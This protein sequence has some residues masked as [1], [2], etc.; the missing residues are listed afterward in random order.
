[1]NF[2]HSRWLHILFA[3]ISV[4]ALLIVGCGGGVSSDSPTTPDVKVR[5]LTG[6]VMIP[7]D[8]ASQRASLR[9][10]A[11]LIPAWGAKVWIEGHSEISPEYTDASGTYTF[12]GVPADVKYVVAKSTANGKILKQR[13][14]VSINASDLT[15]AAPNVNLEEALTVLTG[16]LKD[17]SN[18]FLPYGTELTLWGEPFQVGNDGTFTTLPLPVSVTQAEIF[19]KIF[20]SSA[21]SSFNGSFISG[22]TPAFVEQTVTAPDSSN[23]APSGVLIAE[24]VSG[25]K[26]VSCLAGDRM[27]LNLTPFDANADDLPLLEILW[28]KSKGSLQV[29][30]DKKSAT[31][32]AM[33]SYGVATVSVT[34]T[35]PK[36]ASGKVNLRMLV[37]VQT[38]DEADGKP[39]VILSRTPAHGATG[40][41]MDSR[42]IV[43]F[44]EILL[45]S[46]VPSTAITVSSAGTTVPGTAT[47]SADRKTITWA[48]ATNLPGN[49]TLNVTLSAAIADN[50]GNTIGNQ[51]QWSFSTVSRPYVTVTT[52]LTNDTTPLV[53][54]TVDSTPA[55]MQ[56][57]VKGKTYTP[58]INGTAWTVQVSD[59]LAD[60][61][62]DVLASAT[63]SFGINGSDTTK[64][65]LQIDTLAPVAELS[66][67]PAAV[68]NLT[69]T[70]ITVGGAGVASYRYTLDGGTVSAVKSINEKI[71]LTGL[72]NGIHQLA[73]MGLDG[74]GNWQTAADATSYN[75]K[76]DTTVKTA[77]LSD[78][79]P[80]LTNQTSVS[81]TVGGTGVTRYKYSLDGGSWS[82][83]IVA[84][85]T[86]KIS[87]TGLVSG[88]HTLKVIGG[89]DIGN[90]QAT[91]SATSFTWVVDTN[92]KIAV[93]SQTPTNPSN[94]KTAAIVVGG[95][96]VVSYK[97]S[98]NDGSW[99]SET[100]VAD[101]IEL[102]GLT[103]GN[104]V[105][106]VV[107][108]DE[109]GN[110]QPAGSATVFSWLID[111]ADLTVT[112]NRK[113]TQPALSNAATVYFVAQ[114]NKTVT[115]FIGSDVTLTG[116]ANPTTA[117][118]SPAASPADGKTFLVAVSGMTVDGT[119]IVSLAANVASD[120][121]GNP[122]K[123]STST[124]NQVLRDTVAP[125]TTLT[126]LA[127]DPTNSSP[128]SVT[129]AFSKAISGLT[130]D[131]LAVTNGTAGNLVETTASKTWTFTVVPSA[132]GLVTIDF[133]AAKVIDAAGNGNLAATQLSF[134]YDSA[135]PAA[136]F[137]TTASPTTNIN[138]VPITITFDKAVISFALTDLTLNN[139][140]VGNLAEVVTGKSWT[141]DLIP[142]GNGPVSVD[143]P[144]G[145]VSDAVGNLNT[146]AAQLSFVYDNRKP[147]PLFA[148][149]A[150][151]TTKISPIPFTITFDEAV[152]GFAIG[153]LTVAN[154]T[155]GS[156]VEVVAGKVWSFNVTSPADGAVTV[157]LA[158]D[159]AS[160]VAVNGNAAATPLSVT[161]DS[162]KPTVTLTT[163]AGANP[164]RISPITVTVSFSETVTG[165]ELADLG[166]ING[167]AGN[168]QVLTAGK[169]WKV[170]VTPPAP[171]EVTVSLAAGLASDTAGNG[172]SA[173]VPLVV[174]FDQTEPNAVLSTTASDPTNSLSVPLTIT[175]SEAVL[176]FT[177]ADISVGNGTIAN[178]ATTDNKIW[179]AVITPS[180]DGPVT[181]NLPA[182]KA[183]D[184]AGN[185]NT[186]ATALSF[187]YDSLAPGVVFSSAAPDPT[188]A[189]PVPVTITFSEAMTGF[190]AA[191]LSIG[192]GSA[193]NLSTSDN[194]IW[195]VD[196]V[197]SANDNAV[198][199]LDLAAGKATDAAGNGNTVATQFSITYDSEMPAVALTTASATTN[200]NPIPV[201]VTFS[202]SVTGFELGDLQVVNGTP[203]NLATADNKVYT[204][205][206]TPT[207]SNLTVN[208][209]AGKATDAA[210][211]G[212]TAAAPL[213]IAYDSA[214]PSVAFSTT[215]SSTTRISPVPMTVTF[216]EAVSGF[217]AGD[218][219]IANGSV[220]ALT[221]VDNKVWTF[222][223]TGSVNGP[224]TIDLAADRVVDNAGN[225]NTAA[226]Q[227]SLDF[228]NVEPTVTM[229]APALTN[230]N[231]VAVTITFSKAVTGLTLAAL[232]VTNG[233]PANLNTVDNI[234][235]TAEV[236]PT[237]EGLVT[238]DLAAAKAT[239]VAGNPNAAANT[240]N[241]VYDSG[242][243]GATLAST[244]STTTNISPIPVTIAFS[245]VVASFDVNDLT[246][247]NATV[248]NF[249][250]TVASQTWTF[251]LTP[252]TQGAVT[253]EVADS[254]TEDAAGNG[255][256]AVTQISRTYDSAAP[257]TPI[258]P[259]ITPVG[260]TVV[261]NFLNSTNI[262]L[263]AQATITAGQATGGYAELLID[264][265]AF[266]P[267]LKDTVIQAADTIVTFDAGLNSA[268]ALQA[269]FTAGGE[270]SVR[271]FDAADNAIVSVGN[272][273][274]VVDYSG[275]SAPTSV[276]VSAAG[277]RV[278][279]NAVNTTNTN[280]TASAIISAGQATGGSAEL[281][282]NGSSFAGPI[283]DTSILAGDT[284]VDFTAGTS[285]NAALQA[286][287]TSGGVI[288]VRLID[289]A[290]NVITSSVGNPT[291]LVDY[292]PPAAPTS[293]LL[294]PIGGTITANA[295]NST[296]TG[297][298]AQATIAAGQA[299]G[300]SAE[301]LVGGFSFGPVIVDNNI[302]AGDIVVN[303]PAA[304]SDNPGLR[305]AVPAG[306]EI[307][308]KLIDAAGNETVS[309]TGNPVLLVDYWAPAAPTSITLTPVGGTVVANTLNTT[310]T[311][312]DVS[313]TIAAG[314]ATGGTA[315]LLLDGALLAGLK[316]TDI[317]SGDISV[318]FSTGTSD[319]AALRSA[320]SAGGVISIRLKD[321]T[322]NS[323]VSG[324]G[325]NPTLT[326]DYT[327][328]AAPTSVT[329]TPIS[330]TVVANTL[331]TTSTNLTA[332][333]IIS[334]GQAT[335]GT[336]ELLIGG[337]SF[338]PAI[339][340]NLIAA[341]DTSVNFSAGLN[342]TAAVQTAF[343]ASGSISVRITDAAGNISVSTV[344]NPSL[345]V[346]YTPPTA[347][348]EVVLLPT[349]GT[350]YP[351][352]LN[353]TN[354]SLQASAKIT[355]G[356]A[357]GGEAELLVAGNSFA[358]AIKDSI[359]NA[360]DISVTF[361]TAT[362]SNAALQAFVS[363]GNSGTVSV[364]V[365]DAAGNST[366]S[367][368][369]NPALV[370]DYVAPSLPTGIV[371]TPVGGTVVANAINT[372]NTNLT[373][374]ATIAAGEATGGEAELLVG[375]NS[376]ATPL[377]DT[378]ILA[379][380]T[381]V[382][383]S[384]GTANNPV[385]Q[386]VVTSGGVISVR[387]RDSVGNVSISTV[388]PT[389]LVDYV[390]PS[391]PSGVLIGAVGGT[392]VANALNSTNINLLATASIIANENAS[393]AELLIGGVPF[394][395]P[396]K[397][398]QI[399]AADNTVSFNPGYGSTAALQAAITAGGTISVRVKDRAGNVN[400]STV[401]NPVLTVDY[402]APAAPTSVSLTPVGGTVVAN[403]LNSSNT[404]LTAGATITADQA[405]GGSAELLIG[406]AAFATPIRDLSI[407]AGET[408]VAFD[409]GFA[410]SDALQNAITFG[411]EISV[412]ITDAVGN[413]SVSTVANPSLTVDYSYSSAGIGT[414]KFVPAGTFQ[415][416]ATSTNR[417]SL[418]KFRMS[419][420]EITR[421]Q[422]S[423]IMGSD[424]TNTAY[425][426]G[427]TDPVQMTGWY[428]A[429]A[430][431][432]KLSIA[433][434]LT[435]VYAVSGVNFSTL[436]YA[437]IPTT[438]N[439]NWNAATCNW[440]ANGYRLP[441]EMEW[442]WAAMD[443]DRD[444][445]GQVNTTGYQ[446]LFSG[447]DGS[448]TAADF[449][450]FS[451]AAT[452]PVGYKSANKL[453]I[454][455]L[456]GNVWEWC[457]DYYGVYP[458]GVQ[459]DYRGPVGGTFRITRGGSWSDNASFLTVA[460]RSYDYPYYQAET[461]GFRVVRP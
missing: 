233:T 170:D 141:F 25:V 4:V 376:F 148:T 133:A 407:L 69:Q 310:N 286:A 397:D 260:G 394:A 59:T 164:T 444:N 274:L 217:E 212:N 130:L 352:T 312:L 341:G 272:P 38:M 198:V 27:Y 162:V 309:T 276:T 433:E 246:V 12:K 410:S 114:F 189:S 383:F 238:V 39:P 347:P 450:W 204:F 366:V 255:N 178:L 2:L 249:V 111:T 408:S 62:Y 183:L 428:H 348:T 206:L 110:W 333:A 438:D 277:G 5:T 279:T 283:K 84:S 226:A 393:E 180:T 109:L 317:Q 144:E 53:S 14:P 13:V 96:G 93:L 224:I 248:G 242:R 420:H 184:A 356:E 299:T 427:V 54:G 295:L 368:V 76:V 375:G 160:D 129:L 131:D 71:T 48:P 354:T 128:V 211:N 314:Q 446:K 452:N 258:A 418:T 413:S 112:I 47:L 332:S 411:G 300:G 328:P 216:S 134:A 400:T 250:E 437:A 284:S 115:D 311:R 158:A 196:I 287:V 266:T 254:K 105:L 99:S 29:A 66:G 386:T 432:N 392:V 232:A 301:L 195:S 423:T 334:A 417:S 146:A 203:G 3:V 257:D 20:G 181:V 453:G 273:T 7:S 176:G 40:I 374:Q 208:L 227:F 416:D 70:A 77:I 167:N 50:F 9:E 318:D 172:N 401:A 337:Q 323:I 21:F 150:S 402:I 342:S 97:Y 122:N 72:A 231:P 388:N 361:N 6:T 214:R 85:E 229:T 30:P 169:V 414:L 61:I 412:R 19:V 280:L 256:T 42:I 213:S 56:V 222:N 177:L 275:P 165:F 190:T 16:V 409:A 163:D 384:A 51:P 346:D 357:A 307:S 316:D 360:G 451:Q 120:A 320:I 205:D 194:K 138:P 201:V 435:P 303:F 200:S 370:V 31:W 24:N 185:Y 171:G 154:G 157:S 118:I 10:A 68:T 143:L 124:A 132:N 28:E 49:Q 23:Q 15:T 103:D 365:R 267:P 155:P 58:E 244:A 74:A 367:S 86:A 304:T 458:S 306:G 179:N 456:S 35:D 343:P 95:Q 421:D 219:V 136:V 186:A 126:T 221:T 151:A 34:L 324:A 434:G 362:L 235:W 108:G 241:F 253:V 369:G 18:N 447:S 98:L 125:T 207:G 210:G 218:L 327:A 81:I 187:T 349:G 281:L 424:P 137:A 443:A 338:T 8:L 223:I 140:S 57:V 389:L 156:L 308:V 102:S 319:N 268:A 381:T 359:I 234:V 89:D 117:T 44:D 88:S 60:G 385:L 94:Q 107:A 288:S 79:P 243:P 440:S 363:A 92:V 315:E 330:G 455:D 11:S 364:R 387:I 263:T 152:T 64:N 380:D 406:G 391:A 145:K 91:G 239:D 355:A 106:K 119:I 175:F 265:A 326:V 415:R 270:I 192:N 159:K 251:E 65:E 278:I 305:A 293:I 298:T 90:W 335:G 399:S 422:F 460:Y 426:S 188:N 17:S 225:G 313:A 429:I 123:A 373:A 302:L 161:F 116:T 80:T 378:T 436:T 182:G 448:N 67:L 142:T 430:F 292:T 377:K 78:L 37:N 191:D 193:A 259:A 271:L 147:V 439:A 404:N 449:A 459:N 73:V 425:S 441:T 395:T 339:I 344:A 419:Q 22:T 173:A 121:A 296:N 372:T 245:E 228:D 43:A 32:T 442:M 390:K 209:A 325:D 75:W 215:A 405:T 1:M 371:L 331:N 83:E 353:N 445:P 220:A 104:N 33:D 269:A 230:D 45:P 261:A 247:V 168:L 236:A 139:A 398:M 82:A 350:I 153:D 351:N 340:D 431:C 282:I 290:G 396:I 294:S 403:T 87:L 457:W 174:V 113:D 202:Q 36:G 127:G 461:Q 46:S 252:V 297:L 285:D 41:T 454:Y 199:T 336:A 100:P 345:I 358:T 101:P 135:R 240:L 26:T 379:G 329:L 55:S 166:V 264:G 262:N 291:L 321:A 289:A 237:G 52:L 322:G 197:P 63:N 149:T 382:N